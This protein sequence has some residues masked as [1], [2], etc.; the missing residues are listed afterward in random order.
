ML[1]TSQ[2]VNFSTAK[3]SLHT[4]VDIAF[5]LLSKVRSAADIYLGAHEDI[6]EGSGQQLHHPGGANKVIPHNAE[7]T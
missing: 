5:L 2:F 7:R 1:K 4:V 6:S 3:L